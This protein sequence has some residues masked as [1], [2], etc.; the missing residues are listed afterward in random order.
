MQAASG[1]AATLAA[2]IR[3][4][5]HAFAELVE[6]N[7]ASMVRFA[8]AFVHDRATA[9]EVAQE[10]WLGFLRAL[11][12][13][14]ARSTIR[15]FLLTIVANRARTRARRDVRT[16]P[17][18]ALGAADVDDPAA[19]LEQALEAQHTRWPGP[20]SAAASFGRQPP[21]RLLG[22]ERLAVV[23]DAIAALPQRQRAVIVLRDVHGFSAGET[24][25][26]LGLTEGNQRVL[27]HRARHRVRAALRPYLE[28]C[29]A[30]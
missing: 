11:D 22:R 9:E 6:R 27:L 25:E 10:S 24:R 5:E 4:D 20:W 16:V 21:E 3:G 23:D 13:F 14:E 26:R 17:L 19:G 28:A 18:S 15:S 29:D 2:L 7:H 1:E 30:A 12:R 8:M